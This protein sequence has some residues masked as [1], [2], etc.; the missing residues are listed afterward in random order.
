VLTAAL[1]AIPIILFRVNVEIGLLGGAMIFLA[2]LWLEAIHVVSELNTSISANQLFTVREIRRA[3]PLI[4]SGVLA[5]DVVS[6]FSLPILRAWLGLP[7][8]IFL[9]SGMLLASAGLMLYIT[10]AYKPFFPEAPRRRTAQEKQQDFTVN[11]LKGALWVYVSLVV[12]FFVMVQVVAVLLDFQYLNQIELNLNV[13]IE[14]IAD[15]MALFSACL[16]IFELIT[17][18]FLLGRVI[19]RFGVFLIA[20]VPPALLGLVSLLTLG[21]LLSQFAGVV[22]LKFV[23]ELL[24]YTLVASIGPV[25]FHPIPNANRSRI[26]SFVRGMA[27]PMSIG[28]TGLGILA[29]VKLLRWLS[30]SHDAAVLQPQQSK[31]F[32]VLTALTAFLWI[33]SVWLLRSRYVQILVLGAE[34]D[35]LLNLPKA[36]LKN[37]KRGVVESL[38]RSTDE[39]EKRSC[40]N[41]LMQHELKTIGEVLSPMLRGFSA[42]LQKQSLEAMLHYPNPNHLPGVRDLI[43]SKSLHPEVLALA[44]KYIWHT[45]S[46]RDFQQLRP[47]LQ[48][49]VDPVVR[50]MAASFMLRWGEA[51]QKSEATAT[52]RRMLTHKQERE[53]VMGCR[54]LGEAVYLQ[55]LRLYIEPLLTDE[56]L[57]V[58]CAMLEAIAATH[59]DDYYDALMRGFQFKSTRDAA[60][61][62][63]IRLQDEAL[64]LL[65]EFAADVYKA[66]GTRYQAWRTIGQIGTPDAI[67]LLVKHLKTAWGTHRRSLLKILLRLPQESGIDAI[68]D[69]IGRPGV[70]L[71]INQELGFLAH[72]YASLQDLNLDQNDSE[73]A[74][75]LYHALKD[76]EQD[77]IERVFLLMQFLHEP[78]TIQAA[79]LSLQS[80]ARESVAQGLEILDNTL[81]ISSKLAVLNVLDRQPDEDKLQSLEEIVPYQPLSPSQRLRHLVDL[82]HFLSDWA[83]ACCLHLARDV[84]WSLTADQTL[85]CLQNPTG[86]VREAVLAYLKVASPRSL[87]TLLPALQQDPNPL[88]AAQVQQMMA[89]LG[90]SSLETS[91]PDSPLNSRPVNS[92]PASP[93]QP[94]AFS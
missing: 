57:R 37:F 33:A 88:V 85:A 76:S 35:G 6:G 38:N 82:R 77:T 71:M 66:E 75:M 45:D 4:S 60:R 41:L 48:P 69:S 74:P 58:R 9:A 40:I 39:D 36:E 86:F 56:S 55:S 16:G 13:R 53:R 19:E 11:R 27:E 63:L 26:Q 29:A 80:D 47:Y 3:F 84:R 67:N 18:W 23:D 8:V 2:R 49:N 25:L 70:E 42:A 93:L 21:G 5:A 61:R 72:L 65:T 24:R 94:L 68:A 62:S 17:Q 91:D 22:A 31:I 50:G 15:F 89:E 14:R 90:L 32:L 28:L 34:E 44:L 1:M 81:Q 12:T 7:N 64:P 79:A 92:R 54:A 78:T 51:I 46:A 52:L 73:F 20:A 87:P 59:L 83:L 30:G 43:A 10:Q